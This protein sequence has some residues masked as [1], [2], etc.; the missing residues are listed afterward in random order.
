MNLVCDNHAIHKTSAI[1]K[2]FATHRRFHIYFTPD[3]LVVAKPG[4]AMVC[5]PPRGHSAATPHARWPHS[6]KPPRLDQHLEP[7]PE[8]VY[9]GQS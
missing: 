1:S 9:V 7:K 6:K 3:V 2:W 4:Q 5:L 8:T